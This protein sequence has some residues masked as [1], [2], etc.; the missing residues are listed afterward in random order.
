[1]QRK[2]TLK[3]IFFILK[4]SLGP[5]WCWPLPKNA[6]KLKMFC[7]KLYQF[8]CIIMAICLDLS[9]LYG[10]S[11]HINN[12][13]YVVQQL[14]LSSS[15]IHIICNFISY[16]MKYHNIQNVT[17]KMEKFCDLIKPREKV[18]IQRYID[19][20][21]VFYCTIMCI[22]YSVAIFTIVLLPTLQHQPFPTLAEYPF[23]VSH[24]PL[25]TIIYLCQ[26][27]VGIMTSAHLCL[28]V[29]MAL[30]LWFTSAKFEMLIE[31]MRE[32]TNVYQLF[33]CIKVH[34]ELL[35]Y[36]EEVIF[37]VRPFAFIAVSCATFS[38]ILVF[39]VFVTHQSITLM[40]QFAGLFIIT[41]AEVYMY[42]WPG[43]QLISM[44][45]TK[46][47]Q[48]AFDIFR[49]KGQSIKMH[50]C[51]QIIIMKSR[52]PIIVSIPCFLPELSHKYFSTFCS[53]IMSYFTTLRIIILEDE[54]N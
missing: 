42:A 26:S 17:H 23:D 9:L 47:A 31:E 52:K 44:S 28:N 12:I 38:A 16:Q 29:Y 21:L 40:C 27:V 39:L 10:V 30:L 19:K 11:N 37:V 3:E 15:S 32:T 34:Q 18:V 5:I 6:T 24:Q 13:A 43:E 54:N 53:T 36:A 7:M 46:I 1:M 4:L 14:L 50:K 25:K 20:C 8:W 35:K 41:L 48:A 22:F 33:K 45:S 2:V 51:L 49:A